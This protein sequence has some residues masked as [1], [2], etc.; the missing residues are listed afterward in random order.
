MKNFFKDYF[1]R[2][3]IGAAAVVLTAAVAGLAV[4]VAWLVV[5]D[6]DNPLFYLVAFAIMLVIV[7][8]VGAIAKI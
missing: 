4:L 6:G 3:L 2:F 7:P 5:R 1:R 8:L